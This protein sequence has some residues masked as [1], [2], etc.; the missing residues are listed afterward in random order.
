MN[1]KEYI[2]QKNPQKLAPLTVKVQRSEIKQTGNFARFKNMNLEIV[3]ILGFN[4][5]LINNSGIIWT[6]NEIGQPHKLTVFY[7]IN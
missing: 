5:I 7:L 6:I 1:L 3:Q 4:Y 2:N